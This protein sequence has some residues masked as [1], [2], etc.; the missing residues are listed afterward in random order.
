M[1]K[2]LY[3]ISAALYVCYVNNPRIDIWNC[4]KIFQ[5]IQTEKLPS[6]KASANR[7]IKHISVNA[8]VSAEL[9]GFYIH[10]A[11]TQSFY[12]T[13]VE[14]VNSILHLS[15]G[16]HPAKLISWSTCIPWVSN[17]TQP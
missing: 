5:R 8:V 6:R 17:I 3:L 10:F 4:H 2:Q 12:K 13:T 15:E 16:N 9:T 7:P 14:P 11:Q 1:Q